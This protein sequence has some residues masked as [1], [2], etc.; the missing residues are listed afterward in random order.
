MIVG[1]CGEGLPIYEAEGGSLL[2]WK[3]RGIL[4]ETNGECPNFFPLGDMWVL[5]NG[6]IGNGVRYDIGEFDIEKLKFTSARSGVL[7]QNSSFAGLYGTNIIV[8]DKNRCI[9]LGALFWI[10]R[11]QDLPRLHGNASSSVS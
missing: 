8:D 2:R 5:L 3:Y 6:I 7:D 10:C 1:E 9:L 4:T 11:W